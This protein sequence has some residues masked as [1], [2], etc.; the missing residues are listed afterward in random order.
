MRERE[1]SKKHI[2]KWHYVR[3]YY[4]DTFLGEKVVKW[5][6]RFRFTDDFEMA[7]E[8]DDSLEYKWRELSKEEIEILKSKI[9]KDGDDYRLLGE[10]KK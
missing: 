1:I 10:M 7:Y 8:Y 5:W 4:E 3:E 6:H 2:E 9:I